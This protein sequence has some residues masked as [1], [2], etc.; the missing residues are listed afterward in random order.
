MDSPRT[1]DFQGRSEGDGDL[2]PQSRVQIAKSSTGALA[3]GE[4][5]PGRRSTVAQAGEQVVPRPD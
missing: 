2:L 4:G 1:I 5:D 3:L